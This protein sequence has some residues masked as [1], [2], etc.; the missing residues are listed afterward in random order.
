MINISNSSMHQLSLVCERTVT[1]HLILKCNNDLRCWKM[2]QI[3]L[4]PEMNG[5]IKCNVWYSS[6]S[7]YTCYTEPFM[8]MWS[9]CAYCTQNTTYCINSMG[10]MAVCNSKHNQRQWKGEGE[11]YSGQSDL[12]VTPCG[13]QMTLL[14]FTMFRIN[15]VKRNCTILTDLRQTLACHHRK[16]ICQPQ[17]HTH[18]HVHE[19]VINRTHT[20]LETEQD[21]VGI[22]LIY[23]WTE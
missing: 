19:Q 15:S 22:C 2:P 20:S 6:H 18:T 13:T 16:L 4:K 17:K 7:V 14:R 21:T 11:M 5:Y 10:S 12:R 9:F 1:S 23:S 3:L 8:K